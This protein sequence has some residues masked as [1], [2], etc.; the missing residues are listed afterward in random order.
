MRRSIVPKPRPFAA[1]N[2]AE[3]ASAQRTHRR[4]TKVGRAV[5]WVGFI[6]LVFAALSPADTLEAAEQP[7]TASIDIVQ[8]PHPN[9]PQNDPNR[10]SSAAIL[11]WEHMEGALSYRLT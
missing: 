1:L 8:T 10:C 9:P 6:M 5:L 2:I 7:V 11:R 4:I 3:T